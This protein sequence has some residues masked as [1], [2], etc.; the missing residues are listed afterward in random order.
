[1]HADLLSRRLLAEGFGSALIKD[2]N[3][4]CRTADVRKILQCGL[5]CQ[6]AGLVDDA[7]A[8][9]RRVLT[10]KPKHFDALHMLGV[11]AIQ[12]QQPD[13]AVALIHE[14]VVQN[15]NVAAAQRNLAL[16]L[17]VSGR[18]REAIDCYERAIALE[19]TF[20]AAYVHVAALLVESGQSMRALE[21]CDRGL[22]YHAQ[23]AFLH[24]ARAVALRAGE[25]LEEALTCCEIAVKLQPTSAEAWDKRGAALQDLGRPEESL[26]SYAAAIKLRPDLAPAHHH[27]SMVHL[28][29]G[30]FSPGWELFEYRE[31]ARRD[32]GRPRWHPSTH[33]GAVRVLLHSEQGLGDTLQ[34]CRYAPLV[35]AL[36]AR[37]TLMVQRPLVSLV[38][39][40]G[41][42]I[43]V[44]ADTATP[45]TPDFQCSLLSL[46]HAFRTSA[47]NIP[48]QIPYLA[49]EPPRVRQWRERLGPSGFKIGVCWH[50]SGLPAA[51]GKPFPL[52]KLAPIA[53]LAGVRLISLQK[54]LGVEQLQQL[55]P[56]MFVE[57]L[58]TRFDAGNTGFLDTAAIMESLDLVITCDTSVAH[59]AGALGRPTW[60]A[61]KHV[62]DWRWL[63]DR[64]DSPWYPSVRLFRQL[65]AGDWCSVFDRMLSTLQ[66]RM[67][68][69]C[70][71]LGGLITTNTGD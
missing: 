14:A 63:T 10:L 52:A 59:L 38:Q 3:A 33:A 56:N 32:F 68:L 44:I 46:P 15:P 71:R 53:Q 6:A 61:L 29:K 64:D 5:A 19:S 60:I 55:P 50:G 66:E 69:S 35:A 31:Q 37:V 8:C 41:S 25:R 65:R 57:D 49:A 20:G 30:Q 70:Q 17:S 28:R 11:L 24:L 21:W 9:Y 27:A 1:M 26:Q 12:T 45:P 58:G 22:R 34:F 51:V 39:T 62:A 18:K 47:S 43:S 2:C 42:G 16:A 7:R 23:D 67:M 54:G 36:G 40:L 48:T 13:E 4:I